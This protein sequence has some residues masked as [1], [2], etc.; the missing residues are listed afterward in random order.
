MLIAI[1]WTTVALKYASHQSV[2]LKDFFGRYELFFKYT[3]ATILYGLLVFA[4]FIL[5]IIPGIFWAVKYKM[6]DYLI[7]EKNMGIIEA[8]RESGRIT[9]GSK[10]KLF[11]FLCLTFAINLLG[12]LALG[13]GFL[14]TA[15]IVI[16]ANAYVYKTLT[17][18]T[19]AIQETPTPAEESIQE[20]I[21]VEAI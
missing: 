6:Y 18:D 9:Y 21:G 14:V 4:G 11:G 1:G 3:A 10:W 8:F 5:F 2:A 15:P 17:K 13:I 20:A 7:I 12:I 16:L 19:T